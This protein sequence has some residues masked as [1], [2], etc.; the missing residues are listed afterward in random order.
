[1]KRTTAILAA[2]LALSVTGCGKTEI[3]QTITEEIGNVTTESV[4]QN[5]ESAEMTEDETPEDIGTLEDSGETHISQPITE[6]M[7]D[8]TMES[9][10]QIIESQDSFPDSEEIY[11]EGTLEGSI[12]EKDE[13]QSITVIA[14]PSGES[15]YYDSEYKG[16]DLNPTL[17][18]PESYS[19][20][21]ASC[22]DPRGGGLDSF[23]LLQVVKPLTLTES[24]ELEGWFERFDYIY[25]ATFETDGENAKKYMYDYTLYEVIVLEDLISGEQLGHTEYVLTGMG[26][27]WQDEKDPP[28]GPDD[29]FT[30]AL[31]MPAEGCDFVSSLCGNAFRFDVVGDTAYSRNCYMMDELFIE[32]SE[33]IK[34]LRI[35]TTTENPVLYT[36][37]LPLENLAEY[38]RSDWESKGVCRHFE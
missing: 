36:Q 26:I 5:A 14:P 8:V 9:T 2:L 21:M 20:V 38:L 18:V 6:E 32:G 19:D 3:S 23:Y 37:K 15:C 11:E 17:Y 13:E 7:S 10:S 29:R 33:D 31:S 28:Y 22:T 12:Y 34:E 35:T 16:L 1:M 25:D 4:S 27:E 24:E 30:A